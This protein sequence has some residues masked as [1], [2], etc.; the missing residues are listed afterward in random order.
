MVTASIMH[1]TPKKQSA[2]MI[3][4]MGIT[5]LSVLHVQ[6]HVHVIHH[7]SSTNIFIIAKVYSCSLATEVSVVYTTFVNFFHGTLMSSLN[8]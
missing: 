6:Y 8:W 1:D 2:R 5:F 7:Q 3:P 4:Y